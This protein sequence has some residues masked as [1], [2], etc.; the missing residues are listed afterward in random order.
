MQTH[1]SSSLSTQT[2]NATGR[3]IGAINFLGNSSDTTGNVIIQAVAAE[4]QAPG[5]VTNTG[6]TDLE[7]YLTPVGSSSIE[8]AMSLNAS[9]MSVTILN[10]I[11]LDENKTIGIFTGSGDPEGVQVASPG[12]R[13][14][15]TAGDAGT[16]FYVKESGTGNTGWIGK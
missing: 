14:Y 15:N 5:A 3:I 7:I 1:T 16:T 8:K 11:W 10:T 9:D 12:S 2:D 6:G 13:W 4:D